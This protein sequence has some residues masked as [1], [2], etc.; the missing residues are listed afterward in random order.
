[1]IKTHPSLLAFSFLAFALPSTGATAPYANDF[2]GTGAN[3][4]F[5]TEAADLEWSV[6]GGVYKNTYAQ[7]NSTATTNSISI[8]G[9]AGHSFTIETQFTVQQIGTLN[10]NG[11]TLGFGVFAS[12]ATFGT[13]SGNSLY[14]ADFSFANAT[15]SSTDVGRLRILAQGDTSGFT[16]NTIATNGLADANTSF[17]YLAIETG[18]TYTLRLQG[19]IVGSTLNMTLGL[20]D[21]AG[22][23]QIGTSATASDTS[24]LTGEFFGYRNRISQGGGSST[25]DFDNFSLTTGSAVPEPS[26]Y[27][28][29]GGLGALGVV[30]SQRRIRR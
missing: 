6:T 25:I 26:A 23:T 27:A 10:A 29:L 20:F 9:V 8:T 16:G 30:I 22:T 19:S 7:T 28:L 14:L 18:T 24:P 11:T 1:M 21:A 5:T 4:A 13:T 3:T 15:S 2:S 12:S 17:G